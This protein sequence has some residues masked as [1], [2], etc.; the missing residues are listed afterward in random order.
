M[1]AGS[2]CRRGARRRRPARTALPCPAPR[3]CCCAG[4]SRIALSCC[5][6]RR[7]KSSS[8]KPG[9]SQHLAHQRAP[10]LEVVAMHGAARTS[11]SPCRPAPRSPRPADRRPAAVSRVAARALPPSAIIDAVSAGEAV[12]CPADRAAAPVWKISA[13]STS[14]ESER[15]SSSGTENCAPA[16]P[17]ARGLLGLDGA[18]LRRGRRRRG[19][20]AAR[21]PVA[22]TGIE[23]REAVGA[24]QRRG[25]AIDTVLR[26]RR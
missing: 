11:P 1:A 2:A 24:G 5:C 22:A 17:T 8:R 4:R 6:L 15:C 19:A 21:T 7:A 3:R 18:L 25:V 12:S 26:L 13:T 16:A 10:G 20:R 23:R 9:S 14:G